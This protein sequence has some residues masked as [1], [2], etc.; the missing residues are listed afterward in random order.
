[1]RDE[2][3]L[4]TM[5]AG[6]ETLPTLLILEAKYQDFTQVSKRERVLTGSSGLDYWV[7]LRKETLLFAEGATIENASESHHRLSSGSKSH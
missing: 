1:M 2:M 5:V 4:V 6:S 3:V 7:S